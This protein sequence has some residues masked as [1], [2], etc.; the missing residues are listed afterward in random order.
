MNEMPADAHERYAPYIEA[1]RRSGEKARRNGIAPERVAEAI[2]HAVRSPKPKTR[3][4]VGR[5]ARL[6]AIAIRVL[7]YRVTNRL[8]WTRM[9]MPKRPR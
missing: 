8:T 4:F 1:A 7:P 9:K 5:D 2:A 3:Y 6:R